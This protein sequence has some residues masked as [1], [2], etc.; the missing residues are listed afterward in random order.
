MPA[1]I[2]NTCSRSML[3]DQLAIFG[4]DN[5]G[6]IWNHQRIHWW[7]RPM[8]P[9]IFGYV[10]FF[11]W[12]LS[13]TRADIPISDWILGAWISIDS[14]LNHHLFHNKKSPILLVKPW[15]LWEHH[16]FPM[17]KPPFLMVGNR[18]A[19][20]AGCVTA[21]V[22][23]HLQRCDHPRAQVTPVAPN[24]DAAVPI[25]YRIY[26]LLNMY[27]YIIIYIYIY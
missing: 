11:C 27:M 7:P 23:S 24:C 16:H 14:G 10:R 12:M 22:E 19:Q 4:M 8:I 1:T 2:T 15:F 17:V 3:L 21:V 25:K 26:H 18:P 5:V 6:N 13:S 20:V 9:S